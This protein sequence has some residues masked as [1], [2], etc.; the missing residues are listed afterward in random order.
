MGPFLVVAYP[1]EAPPAH[2]GRS[3]GWSAPALLPL[4]SENSTYATLRGHLSNS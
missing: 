4:E 3:S 1:C 2:P